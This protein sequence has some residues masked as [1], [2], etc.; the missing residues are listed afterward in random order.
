MRELLDND[1]YVIGPAIAPDS[2]VA[3]IPVFKPV[4]DEAKRAQRREAK[5]AKREAEAAARAAR[6]AGEEKRR[7]ALH[8][9]KRKGRK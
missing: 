1:G 2:A 8:K 3:A 7:E 6:A 5:A 9:S 4:V